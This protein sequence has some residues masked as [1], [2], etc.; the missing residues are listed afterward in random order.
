MYSPLAYDPP[1][2]AGPFIPRLEFSVLMILTIVGAT[3]FSA[4][5]AFI[6]VYRRAL[7]R[8]SL[9]P[10]TLLRPRRDNIIP[11]PRKTPSGEQPAPNIESVN[12]IR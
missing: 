10:M 1:S 5:A 3:Y 7:R 11:F 9:H 6:I 4:C 8:A 2:G 12:N